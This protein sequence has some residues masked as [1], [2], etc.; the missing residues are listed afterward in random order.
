MATVTVTPGVSSMAGYFTTNGDIVKFIEGEQQLT[1]CDKSGSNRII[2]KVE[3]G[4][5]SRVFTDS[6]D[7]LKFD[8]TTGARSGLVTRSVGSRRIHCFAAGPTNIWNVLKNLGNNF[9]VM[10][11]GRFKEYHQRSGEGLANVSSRVDAAYILGGN[12]R[13]QLNA[14][15]NTDLIL[16]LC[17]FVSERGFSGTCTVLRGAKAIF[18]RAD[19][20]TGTMP[21]GGV[22]KV[23][24]PGDC[25]WCL[26]DLDE[27]WWLDG[28]FT[29]RN[30]PEDFAI[31]ILHITAENK[32]KLLEQLKSANCNVTLP[33]VVGTDL[34]VYGD[35]KDDLS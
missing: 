7:P 35:E 18:K 29:L 15:L 21:T 25:E 4:E 24:G 6:A 2:D 20:S 31:G 3:I 23:L 10:L 12:Y 34:F 1:N 5:L 22:L 17:S 33:S 16:K 26:G 19:N 13:Q 30:A 8:M 14:N 9:V 27:L 11:G 28:D 32:K